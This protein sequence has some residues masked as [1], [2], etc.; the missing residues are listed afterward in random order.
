[1]TIPRNNTYRNDGPVP[2]EAFRAWQPTMPEELIGK[3]I[4][5]KGGKII[6]YGRR[7]YLKSM[8]VKWMMNRMRDG[9]DIL[10][11]PTKPGGVAS[12]YAQ[13]EIAEALLWKRDQAMY[14]GMYSN[15]NTQGSN[16]QSLYYWTPPILKLD[17]KEGFATLK[18][19]VERLMPI[20]MVVL[21]AL[22]KM[23]EL[24]VTNPDNVTAFMDHVDQ[25]L[26][27][28]NIGCI[29][30]AHPRK[31]YQNQ[32]QNDDPDDLLGSSTWYN[33]VDAILKIKKPRDQP[34]D[35]Y[36]L[37]VSDTRHSEEVIADIPYSFDRKTL[38]FNNAVLV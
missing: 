36:L 30:I 24:G 20:D 2:I 28:F 11:L 8:L 29:I 1:M 38:T 10:G 26:A 14:K 5:Y 21:D 19:W 22:Y 34:Q 16:S 6:L 27:E 25:V 12:L 4:L 13:V 18:H 3:G 37:Q 7:K 33:W 31:T 32:E 17:T 9:Q 35:V 23:L 15:G